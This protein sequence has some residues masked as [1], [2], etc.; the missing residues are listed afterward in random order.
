M[1]GLAWAWLHYWPVLRRIKSSIQTK[2]RRPPVNADFVP[3]EKVNVLLA[4]SLDRHKA[5][6]K[7]RALAII[8]PD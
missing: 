1:P 4:E 5:V 2:L 8:Q 7:A 6:V 3:R